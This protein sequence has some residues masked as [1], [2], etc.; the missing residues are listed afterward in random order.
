MKV[1]ERLCAIWI[2]DAGV[3]AECLMAKQ[4]ENLEQ[5]QFLKRVRTLHLKKLRLLRLL[6]FFNSLKLSSNAGIC[7]SYLA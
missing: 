1:V 5:F 7:N 3:L 6:M 4:R 2:G